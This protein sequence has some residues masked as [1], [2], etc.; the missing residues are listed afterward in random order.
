LVLGGNKIAAG[1]A[2]P[3]AQGISFLAKPR[4][5]DGVS[6]STS[7]REMSRAHFLDS[8]IVWRLRYLATGGCVSYVE[9]GFELSTS[10][11]QAL[12]SKYIANLP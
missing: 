9:I 3:G 5:N 12:H 6:G 7:E 1:A 10:V 11:P 8:A 4:L 2:L